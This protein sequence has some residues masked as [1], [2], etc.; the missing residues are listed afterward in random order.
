MLFNLIRDFSLFR[1]DSFIVKTLGT[2]PNFLN[3]TRSKFRRE[4]KD[5]G[6]NS[7]RL[8]F[9]DLAHQFYWNVEAKIVC[10]TIVKLILIRGFPFY[11]WHIYPIVSLANS[12]NQSLHENHFINSFPRSLSSQFSASSTSTEVSLSIIANSPPLLEAVRC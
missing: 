2:W 7:G 3:R 5:C 11:F 6:N 12:S 1:F 8:F 4:K 9:S 10:F